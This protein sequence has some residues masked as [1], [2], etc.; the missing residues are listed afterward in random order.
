MGGAQKNSGWCPDYMRWRLSAVV[1][2]LVVAVGVLLLCCLTVWLLLA[3]QIHRASQMLAKVQSVNVG[4]SEGSIGPLLKRFGG[5][6][7]D[8]Q[9]GAHED[10]NYVM[11]IN[12]WLYPTVSNHKWR[13]LLIGID[14][15]AR[16]RRAVGLRQWLIT[17]EIAIRKQ[18]VVAVQADVY[19]E[20]KTMWLGT[21]WRL[22]EK[23]REFER[24]P[25]VDYLQ[26]PPEPDL[27][28]VSPAIL[29]M[30]NGGGNYWR[31]W[32]KPS[33]PTAQREVSNRWN[34]GCLDSL[35]GCDTLCDLLPDTARFF[36]EHN[37][38]AP[39]GGGWDEN[40]RSCLKH[41]P[42]QSQYQ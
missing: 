19:V 15:N 36:S 32:V 24:D 6:R 12:P 14:T 39:N 16:F 35:R 26:W 29:E 37:E 20:G 25:S 34:F 41:D 23:P 21:S 40:L 27:D 2:L 18:Q 13:E 1:R 7:W 28:Y 4:D 3:Y 5:Y 9:L 33:S 38:L 22:S 30:G 31:F 11:E 10:Y 17:S 42:Y 8:A